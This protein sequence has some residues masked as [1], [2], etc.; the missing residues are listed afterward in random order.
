MAGQLYSTDR[1]LTPGSPDSA[2]FFLQVASQKYEQ[3]EHALQEAR[4]VQSEQQA[5][6]Q[7]V[8]RQQEHLRQQEQHV[9]QARLLSPSRAPCQCSLH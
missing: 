6:L 4:R 7:V 5:R 9:H 1:H 8:Q 2:T 3:G